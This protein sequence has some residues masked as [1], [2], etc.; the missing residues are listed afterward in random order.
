[1]MVDNNSLG[2]TAVRAL[3]S[4]FVACRSRPCYDGSRLDPRGKNRHLPSR[5]NSERKTQFPLSSS[6]RSK[7]DTKCSKRSSV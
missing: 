6:G 3:R 4:S 1:M 7:P 5:R 2:L